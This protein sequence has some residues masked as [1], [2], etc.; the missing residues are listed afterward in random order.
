MSPD[1]LEFSRRAN[2]NV[3]RASLTELPFANASFDLVTSFDVLQ[4]VPVDESARAVN[5]IYRVLRPGGVAFLRVSAYQW[6]RS[7]HDDALDVKRRFSL[8]ELTEEMRRAG[9]QIRRATYANTLLF[10]VAVGK[11][12]AESLPDARLV[13]MKGAGHMAPLERHGPFNRVLERFLA[14]AFERRPAPAER[15]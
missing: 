4:H 14:D 15:A 13:T 10:P 7:A 6:M 1:A 9:F 8:K 3:S 12:L 2:R 5:E 11:R